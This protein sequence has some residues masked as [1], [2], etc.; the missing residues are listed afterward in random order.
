MSTGFTLPRPMRRARGANILPLIN[1]V[2]L[3]LMFIVLAGVV[4]SPDPFALTPPVA[5]QGREGE[6]PDPDAT[7]YVSAAGEIRFRNAV[8]DD[9]AVAEITRLAATGELT[10]LTLRADA[11]APA[12][13]IV[14]LVEAIRAAGIAAV[15]LQTERRP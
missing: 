6:A 5:G 1:V 2:F 3:L 13:R 11:S 15:E 8:A 7:L 14:K 10:A 12:V 9:A 4:R